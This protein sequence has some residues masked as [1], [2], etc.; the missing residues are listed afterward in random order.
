MTELQIIYKL[1]YDYLLQ[2]LPEEVSTERL[3]EYFV[4]DSRNFSSLQDVFIQLLYSF[5]HNSHK[6]QKYGT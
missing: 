1:A 4:G 2:I 5:M 3:Q 6:P